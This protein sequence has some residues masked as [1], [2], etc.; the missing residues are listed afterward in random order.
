MVRSFLF[1]D[2]LTSIF[3]FSPFYRINTPP[4]P[5]W[6]NWSFFEVF[7]VFW[8]F[9][10][11]FCKTDKRLSFANPLKC[12]NATPTYCHFFCSAWQGL[13]DL[14]YLCLF[15]EVFWS[16]L[17]FFLNFFCKTDKI[18]CFFAAWSKNERENKILYS[19]PLKSNR[20]K[21]NNK[22][23]FLPPHTP[24]S[25]LSRCCYKANTVL[26]LNLHRWHPY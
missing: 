24:L 23:S 7:E 4:M 5:F 13:I 11:F 19:S 18:K 16:F 8:S 10:I 25:I 12:W 20:F 2:L 22:Y 6:K 9:F 17:K 1:F 14:Y 26:Y 3:L 21:K 15:V